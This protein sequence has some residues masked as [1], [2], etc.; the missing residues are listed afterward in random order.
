MSAD[1]SQQFLRDLDKKLWTWDRSAI[2]AGLDAVRLCLPWVGIG[3]PV[4]GYPA[5][6]YRSP[7]HGKTHEIQVARIPE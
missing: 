1:N 7:H 2:G 4:I 6:S 5:C 3:L